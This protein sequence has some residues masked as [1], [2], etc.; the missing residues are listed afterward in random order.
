MKKF[1]LFALMALCVSVAQAVTIS[2]SGTKTLDSAYSFEEGWDYT[3]TLTITNGD[4]GLKSLLATAPAGNPLL[5]GINSVLE[6]L[7]VVVVR[8][9]NQWQAHAGPNPTWSTIDY[10]PNT[11]LP[12][13]IFA[14]TG[15]GKADGGLTNV[16][17]DYVN[18]VGFWGAAS[19]GFADKND[20][21]KIETLTV[22][23][24]AQGTLTIAV[25]EPTA[26]A[27]L[28]LGVAGLALKRK[29]A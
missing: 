12:E 25:P 23:D 21:A 3:L 7:S 16:K 26:L 10:I 28:A 20:F 4:T 14:I 15:T 9:P 29:V 1:A 19:A 18:G 17:I 8:D 13:L 24:G 2:W 27:L 6:G 5:V 11:N 22:L